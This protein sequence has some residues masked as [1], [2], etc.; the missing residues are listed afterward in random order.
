VI[1]LRHCW[2]W[3]T[4]ALVCVTEVIAGR[5]LSSPI[6][7][8][9][10]A[11]DSWPPVPPT[12]PYS[13]G[14]GVSGAVDDPVAGFCG[15]A[16]IGVAPYFGLYSSQQV[17]PL[18]EGWATQVV[19]YTPSDPESIDPIW[20]NPA[21]ALGPA[22]G[23]V[24]HVVSLGDLSAQDL[25]DGKQ[26]GTITLA[27][28]SALAMDRVLI[29][30]CLAILFAVGTKIWAKMAYVEV[31]TDGVNFARFPNI[32]TNPRPSGMQWPYMVSDPT[33]C[34]ISLARR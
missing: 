28:A 21:N 5:S 7:E 18:F 13:Y 25:A 10:A 29:L 1:R 26:P 31:S 4:L 22:S 30:Y 6:S 24:D 12:G 20:M 32:N 16:G 2:F 33:G 34:I 3:A 23:D 8:T 14:Y 15:P 11:S 19:D 27:A 17:N 9:D